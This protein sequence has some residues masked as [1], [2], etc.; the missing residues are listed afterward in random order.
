MYLAFGMVERMA[1][2]AICR[3]LVKA[4]EA[5]GLTTATAAARMPNTSYQTLFYLEGRRK[6]ARP[7]RAPYVHI[8]TA[9]DLLRLYPTLKLDDFVPGAT[10]ATMVFD[11]RAA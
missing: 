4:R 11:G 9:I 2:L 1:M 10:D 8:G 5:L 6:S 7:K 3:K